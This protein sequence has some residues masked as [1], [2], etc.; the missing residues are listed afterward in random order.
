[1][2]QFEAMHK[3]A[4]IK[5]VGVGG[6]G[7][8]AVTNMMQAGI[9]GVEF[10]VA[11]TDAQALERNEAPN[12]IHLGK[13]ITKGLGA[14]GNPEIGQKSAIED[15]EF[16]ADSLKG[17]DIVFVTA[18]MG[19]GTGTGAAPVIAS[20]AKDLG[21]LTV[22]V[23]STPFSWEGR[24]RNEFAEK[25]LNNLRDHVDSYI[26]V[27]ND[28]LL[29]VVDKNT[30]LSDGFKLAD[31]VLRQ[32]VQGIS[33]TINV[34][35]L[36]NLDCAD[37]RSIMDSRGLALMGVGSSA[38]ENRE[39]EALEKALKGPLLADA[40]IRGAYGIL[41]NITGG[42]D[43]KMYEIS[44]IGSMINEYAGQEANIYVG[45]VNDGR[46]DG[47]V[48]VV[49]VATGIN[50]QRGTVV[51]EDFLPKRDANKDTQKQIIDKARRDLG[52]KPAGVEDYNNED[53]ELPTYLRKQVD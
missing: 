20:V 51:L 36:I 2:F 27:P 3:G 38:G 32:G 39:R 30:S 16:I 31:D 42:D 17:A 24:R 18:G 40:N 1:M 43:L 35:G 8:N 15:M 13:L 12:K 37:V 33:D 4:I 23:V 5:V 21:A 47:S 25:G 46:S 44:N 22:A 41:L 49:L 19:G 53:Y 45:A 48:K 50:Q 29:E 28:R 7:G 52:Q 26:V 11:N 6:A 10:I 14:G 34:P 9:G